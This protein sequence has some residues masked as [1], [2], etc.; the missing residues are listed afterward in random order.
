MARMEAYTEIPSEGRDA[1][2]YPTRSAPVNILGKNVFDL[3]LQNRVYGFGTWLG[4][5]DQPMPRR[6]PSPSFC[7]GLSDELSS[8]GLSPCSCIGIF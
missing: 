4:D 3:Q 5:R 1:W 8:S 7:S 2:T 6:M